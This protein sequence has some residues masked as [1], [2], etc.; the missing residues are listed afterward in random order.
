VTTEDQKPEPP[1]Q[2]SED[3]IAQLRQKLED[4][5]AAIDEALDLLEAQE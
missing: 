2:D 3:V 4:A 5:Q 1:E